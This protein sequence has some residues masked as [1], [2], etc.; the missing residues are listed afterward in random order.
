MVKLV[1]FDDHLMESLK[2]LHESA[3]YLAACLNDAI[4]EKD[5]SHFFKATHAVE[6]ATGK[7]TGEAILL[8]TTHIAP[9]DFPNVN[10]NISI[11]LAKLVGKVEGSYQ[12]HA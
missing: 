12:Q 9:A 10:E 5:E 8:L 1:K 2:D 3:Y 11:I 7:T 6:K 4:K